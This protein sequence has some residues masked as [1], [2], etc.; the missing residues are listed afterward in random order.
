[1]AIICLV[2]GMAGTLQI[3]SHSFIL[4]NPVK[5]A[6]IFTILQVSKPKSLPKVIQL[7][8]EGWNSNHI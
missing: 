8:N 1:M 3:L 2:P 7:I 5:V 6:I 4:K